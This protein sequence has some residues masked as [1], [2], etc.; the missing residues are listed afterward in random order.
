MQKSTRER[1]IDSVRQAHNAGVTIIAG[2]DAGVPGFPQG[3][4]LKEVQAYVDLVGM[5]PMQAMKSLTSTTARVLSL[6]DVT[7]SLQP[8]RSADMVVLRENPLDDIRNLEDDRARVAVYQAG[9]LVA[10][11]PHKLD[12]ELT[13]S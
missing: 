11:L 1:H 12:R 8:G 6:D 5:S 7:G 10:G 13:V 3:G 4:A 2:S 9:R